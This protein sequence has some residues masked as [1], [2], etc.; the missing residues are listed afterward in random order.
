[1]DYQEK[2]AY[3]NSIAKRHLTEKNEGLI[4]PN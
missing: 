1:M 2:R 4:K 3:F